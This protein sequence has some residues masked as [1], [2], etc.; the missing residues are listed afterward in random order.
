MIRAFF[1]GVFL[2]SDVFAM[3]VCWRSLDDPI[4]FKNAV[5]EDVSVRDMDKQVRAKVDELCR[6]SLDVCDKVAILWYAREVFASYQPGASLICFEGVKRVL[7]QEVDGAEVSNYH[8]GRCLLQSQEKSHKDMSGSDFELK[9]EFD[10][11]ILYSAVTLLV[12]EKNGFKQE[13]QQ[14]LNEWRSILVDQGFD[15][16]IFNP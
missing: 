15:K 3:D 1:L 2:M 9:E 6:S 13:A 11:G 10:D 12:N 7:Q 5:L 16:E 4:R 14:L 8:I